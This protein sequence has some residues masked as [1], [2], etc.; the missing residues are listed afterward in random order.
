MDL[1]IFT[2]LIGI[3]G[4]AVMDLWALLRKQL[5]NIPPTNWAMVGRWI[6]YIPKGKLIHDHIA[7]SEARPCEHLIGWLAHYLIGISYA[8]ILTVIFGDEWAQSPAVGPALAVGITTV[9]APFL[10]M[11]PGMGAGIAASRTAKPNATR[12]H[13]IINHLIFGLGL[14]LSGWALNS[15]YAM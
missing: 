8:A 12:I 15:S 3:G 4:T 9:L 6:A 14:Y 10:I 2:I 13:S 1:I 11:Q 7:T 5:F